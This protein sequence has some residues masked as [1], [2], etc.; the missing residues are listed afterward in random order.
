[1]KTIPSPSEA[2]KK[3]LNSYRR[4]AE[5]LRKSRVNLLFSNVFLCASAP[6]R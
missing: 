1:M 4:G 5:A 6:L 3:C 2:V